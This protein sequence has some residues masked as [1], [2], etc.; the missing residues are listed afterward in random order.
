MHNIQ[1]T[2]VFYDLRFVNEQ[3]LLIQKTTYD[4]T[5][6]RSILVQ[7]EFDAPGGWVNI[8]NEESTVKCMYSRVF[9]ILP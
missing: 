1:Q 8:Y 9:K 7:L 3:E 4:K 2:C 6:V 5:F